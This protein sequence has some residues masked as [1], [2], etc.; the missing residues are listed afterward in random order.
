MSTLQSTTS[1]STIFRRSNFSDWKLLNKQPWNS[2]LVGY[3]IHATNI[4]TNGMVH[5]IITLSVLQPSGNPVWQPL[6]SQTATRQN[7]KLTCIS[8][9]H[10]IVSFCSFL[11]FPWHKVTFRRTFQI[12]LRL[13][14]THSHKCFCVCMSLVTSN[15]CV[16]VSFCITDDDMNNVNLRT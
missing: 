11:W 5:P 13:Q 8:P 3:P 7:T 1:V 10:S 6:W 2:H 15:A 12:I 16:C 9:S 4:H 14:M